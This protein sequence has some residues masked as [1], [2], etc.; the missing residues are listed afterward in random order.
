MGTNQESKAPSRGVFCSRNDNIEHDIGLKYISLVILILFILC[1]RP[2][3][4]L[5][6]LFF[7]ATTCCAILLFEQTKENTNAEI[8]G[9]CTSSNR[10]KR[11]INPEM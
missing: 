11:D 10:K 3:Q 1:K 9:S 5:V 7:F 6:K 2:R 4:H 8:D